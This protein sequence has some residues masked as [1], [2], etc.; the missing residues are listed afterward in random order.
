MNPKLPIY[1]IA[2]IATVSILVTSCKKESDE[3][4]VI[5]D[6]D[7]NIYTSLTINTQTW[8]LE[9]LKTTKY[10]DGKSIPLETNDTEWKNLTAPGYCWYDNDINYKDTYGALYNWHA[11]NTDKLCPM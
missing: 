8:L 5:K 10:N 9:N 3:S 2:L 7:G 11:V 1:L 4:S 6:G